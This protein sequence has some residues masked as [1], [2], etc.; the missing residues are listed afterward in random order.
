M[1]RRPQKQASWTRVPSLHRRGTLAIGDMEDLVKT[2]KPYI[3]TVPSNSSA[4]ESTLTRSPSPASV[5]TMP[6]A[7]WLKTKP[8]SQSLL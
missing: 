1:P 3:R 2:S 8:F 6:L 4:K 5:R 7:L